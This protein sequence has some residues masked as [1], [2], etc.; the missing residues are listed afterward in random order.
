MSSA[1][2]PCHAPPLRPR[3]PF[4]SLTPLAPHALLHCKAFF[5]FGE[6]K[7]NWR[8]HK[9]KEIKPMLATASI[10][11]IRPWEQMSEELVNLGHN[12]N[13]SLRVDGLVNALTGMGSSP[14]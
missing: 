1:L 6:D 12:G 2:L 4:A 13:E 3:S 7:R 9:E 8:G 10:E 5:F 14:G 11:A